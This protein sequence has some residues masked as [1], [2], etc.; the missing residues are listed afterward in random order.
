MKL[1]I[2]W[3]YH[4]IRITYSYSVVIWKSLRCA[5]AFVFPTSN[6]WQLQLHSSKCPKYLYQCSRYTFRECTEIS[7]DW[8][9]LTVPA[10]NLTNVTKKLI[11]IPSSEFTTQS[12]LWSNR[13]Q[14]VYLM[15]RRLDKFCKKMEYYCLATHNFSFNNLT[16]FK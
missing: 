11:D 7:R 15:F 1:V 10:T 5:C 6:S 3:S 2:S 4:R 12:Q 9:A 8:Q 13:K 16:I 14:P